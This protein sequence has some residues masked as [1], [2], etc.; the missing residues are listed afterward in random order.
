MPCA[1][2]F[3][4]GDTLRCSRC[5]SAFYCSRE[6]QSAHWKGGHKAKC[7]QP[8]AAKAGTEEAEHADQEAT[9]A[10]LKLKGGSSHTDCA[11]CGAPEGTVPGRPLHNSCSR[12]KAAWYCSRACQ[13][14]HWK[15]GGH[16]E[17]CVTPEQRRLHPTASGSSRTAS[18]SPS[19]SDGAAAEEECA[20]CLD[21]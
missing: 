1:N 10:G 4:P 12:C 7:T 14:A 13:A 20:I 8:T 18:G 9:K 17:N 11:H 16:K 21:S 19:S 2:C 6:C 3:A 15:T 5:K